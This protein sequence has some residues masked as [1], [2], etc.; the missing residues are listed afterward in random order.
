MGQLSTE[1]KLR[2]LGATLSRMILVNIASQHMSIENY[3]GKCL[4]C[5]PTRIGTD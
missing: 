5:F 3:K 4:K 1:L 2:S